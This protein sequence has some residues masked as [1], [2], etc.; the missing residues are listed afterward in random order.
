MRS[1]ASV[2]VQGI[3]EDI[4][5]SKAELL[6]VCGHAGF[7]VFGI[8][9]CWGDLRC[10]ELEEGR[11]TTSW[12]FKSQITNPERS[13][14]GA[15][16]PRCCAAFP[17]SSSSPACTC[18]RWW[19]PGTAARIAKLRHSRCCRAD[20]ERGNQ[21]AKFCFFCNLRNDSTLVASQDKAAVLGFVWSMCNVQWLN[22]RLFQGSRGRRRGQGPESKILTAGMRSGFQLARFL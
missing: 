9:W 7:A 19:A 20:K 21:R 22:A 16:V 15:T 12:Q 1:W 6:G 3:K 10:R 18:A 14:L 13:Q 8:V 2:E 11:P 17:I 5:S 4:Q